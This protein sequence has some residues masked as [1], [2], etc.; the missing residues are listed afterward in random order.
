MKLERAGDSEH[1]LLW[2]AH[3]AAVCF[4]SWK[5]KLG[6]PTLAKCLCGANIRKLEICFKHFRLLSNT[7][8]GKKNDRL[9]LF[10]SLILSDVVTGTA[11]SIVSAHIA[12]EPKCRTSKDKK[13]CWGGTFICDSG[14]KL[15]VLWGESCC[16]AWGI[17]WQVGSC[18]IDGENYFSTS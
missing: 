11:K 4:D 14:L 9:E 1:V 8:W 3:K 7:C 15:E 17:G 2:L 12:E 18:L 10:I 5:V 6:L 16:K 13:D